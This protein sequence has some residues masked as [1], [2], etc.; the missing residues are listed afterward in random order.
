MDEAIDGAEEIYGK[1]SAN[2]KDFFDNKYENLQDQRH[3]NTLFCVIFGAV[4]T[5]LIFM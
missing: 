1:L 4:I 5:F 3:E 2:A